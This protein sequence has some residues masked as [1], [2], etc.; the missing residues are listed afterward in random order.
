M[1][2]L[3]S[4]TI[5]LIAATGLCYAGARHELD[6]AEVSGGVLEART[7]VLVD[8]PKEWTVVLPEA[9]VPDWLADEAAERVFIFGRF[10]MPVNCA[11]IETSIVA[12]GTVLVRVLEPST[13][14]GLATGACAVELD[15]DHLASRVNVDFYWSEAVISFVGSMQPMKML[16]PFE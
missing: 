3:A 11:D 9:P 2:T 13:G 14:S 8:N 15:G 16:E 5:V 7:M 6:S 10:A 4:I 12:E 1:R